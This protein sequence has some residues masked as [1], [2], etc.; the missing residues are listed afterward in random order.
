[1]TQKTQI[2]RE[3]GSQGDYKILTPAANKQQKQ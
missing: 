1:M 3:T 2:L